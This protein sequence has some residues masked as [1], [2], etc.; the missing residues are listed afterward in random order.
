MAKDARPTSSPPVPL[1]F[2]ER[3][4]AYREAVPPAA[5]AVHLKLKVAVPDFTALGLVWVTSP[6]WSF[7]PASEAAKTPAEAETSN[8]PKSD[9]PPLMASW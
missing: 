1:P 9:C 8:A 4:A 7:V 3:P 6:L 2:E 5:G